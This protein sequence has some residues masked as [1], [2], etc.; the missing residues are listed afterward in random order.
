M[1]GI[2]ETKEVLLAIEKIILTS[3]ETFKDGFQLED[4]SRFLSLFEDV[5]KAIEGAQDIP[6]EMKDLDQEEITEIVAF[7]IALVFNILKKLKE[8]KA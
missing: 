6:T 4:V 1:A 2:Q 8:M 7:G 3:M 5:K